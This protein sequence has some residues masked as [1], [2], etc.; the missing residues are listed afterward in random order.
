MG[1]FVL[2]GK[3]ISHLLGECQNINQQIFIFDVRCQLDEHHTHIG[4]FRY[5]SR[6][7]ATAH[8]M[9]D[10]VKKFHIVVVTI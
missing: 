3:G 6:N 10:V 9:I 1:Y 4:D 7:Q 5:L 8:H 2:I